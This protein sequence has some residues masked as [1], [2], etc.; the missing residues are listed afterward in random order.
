VDRNQLISRF[1]NFFKLSIKIFEAKVT[2]LL[3]INCFVKL[4]F[5]LKCLK[6]FSYN[7]IAKSYPGLLIMNSNF[8]E[9]DSGKK[10]FYVE[11]FSSFGILENLI[12]F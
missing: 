5:L 2:D 1:Y 7:S 10:I 4:C 12:Y 9:M 6:K 3:K 8:T 11:Y